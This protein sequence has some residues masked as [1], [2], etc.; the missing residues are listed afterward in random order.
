MERTLRLYLIDIFSQTRRRVYVSSA[1]RGL[2][3][4]VMILI[5]HFRAEGIT[6]LYLIVKKV[7]NLCELGRPRPR[8]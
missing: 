5:V 2:E 7:R 8:G 6:I 3:N 4:R 1:L